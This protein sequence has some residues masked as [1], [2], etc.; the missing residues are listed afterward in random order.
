MNEKRWWVYIVRCRDGTLYTGMTDDVEKRV[1]AHNRGTG[2]KY[3]RSRTPVTLL[4]REELPDR[5]AA[6]RRESAIKKLP[7]AEKLRLIGEE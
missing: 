1:A 6:L 7:R 2:A 5:S 3:T 4:Y